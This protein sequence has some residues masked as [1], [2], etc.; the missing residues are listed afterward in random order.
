MTTPLFPAQEIGSLMKPSW[1]L[2]G[3]RGLPLDEEA[4][5]DFARWDRALGFSR[6]APEAAQR[7]LKGNGR[8]VAADSVRDLGALFALRL[9]ET[10]GLARVYDGEARRVEMYEYP[11]RQMRGFQFVGHVRSIDNKY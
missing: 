5:A 1:Q 10:A 6:G 9:F 2:L 7:L 11:I 8:T 3:Q 4:R